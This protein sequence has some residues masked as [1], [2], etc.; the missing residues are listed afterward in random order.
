MILLKELEIQSSF[1]KKL[2]KLYPE[3][4][5]INAVKQ[6]RKRL[7][8]VHMKLETTDDNHDII[9]AE[10]ILCTYL[11]EKYNSEFKKNCKYHVM[12]IN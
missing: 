7:Y 11:I 6:H 4:N 1:M 8:Q 5:G 2:K 3:E 10:I 9:V 12:H